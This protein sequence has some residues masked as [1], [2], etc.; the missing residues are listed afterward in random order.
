MTIKEIVILVTLL[1]DKKI[2]NLD[3]LLRQEATEENLEKL[4]AKLNT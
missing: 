2:K 1:E 4:V 3:R